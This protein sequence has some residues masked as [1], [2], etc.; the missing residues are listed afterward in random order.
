MPTPR[1]IALWGAVL[2]A[3]SPQPAA[4]PSATFDRDDYA[5][6]AGARGIVVDDFDRNGWPDIAQANTTRNSVTI[7]LNH[8]MA[9]LAN[10]R[11][12]RIHGTV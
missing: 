5:S 4:A 2:L 9:H 11:P 1:W 10:S 3:A 8:T 12:K 6:F 7:L